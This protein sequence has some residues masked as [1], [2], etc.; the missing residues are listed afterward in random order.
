[1]FRISAD[2][3][4]AMDLYQESFN[5]YSWRRRFHLPRYVTKAESGKFVVDAPSMMAGIEEF[6]EFDCPIEAHYAWRSKEHAICSNIERE[7]EED[8]G[9]A[10]GTRPGYEAA[11]NRGRYLDTGVETPILPE[12]NEKILSISMYYWGDIMPCDMILT[13]SMEAAKFL[14][15]DYKWWLLQEPCDMLVEVTRVRDF[16]RIMRVA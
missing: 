5:K 10:I 14:I 4:A 16:Y 15:D 6:P 13:P 3:L 12:G 2:S 7:I 8:Q 1:M 11:H 9:F